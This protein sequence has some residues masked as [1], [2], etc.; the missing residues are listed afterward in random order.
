MTREDAPSFSSTEFARFYREQQ[1]SKSA[2][3]AYRQAMRAV[4][5]MRASLITLRSCPRITVEQAEAGW[6]W[7]YT[8]CGLYFLWYGPALLYIGRSRNLRLRL[9]QH[10]RDGWPMG[11][12]D[13]ITLLRIDRHAIGRFEAVLINRLRPLKNVRREERQLQYARRGWLYPYRLLAGL[14]T[15]GVAH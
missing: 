15:L 14:E 11:R 2:K 10:V 8:E 1:R 7:R 6:G 9:S 12:P 5:G 13:S 3:R 4:W